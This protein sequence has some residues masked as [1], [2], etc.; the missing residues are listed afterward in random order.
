MGRDGPTFTFS[1]IPYPILYPSIRP[2]T[3]PRRGEDA[4]QLRSAIKSSCT[5]LL[6]AAARRARMPPRYRAPRAAG[7]CVRTAARRAARAHRRARVRAGGRACG[8]GHT[9]FSSTR[10][11]HSGGSTRR[12]SSL[13][14]VRVAR[15]PTALLSCSQRAHALKRGGASRPA[16]RTRG[17][18]VEPHQCQAGVWAVVASTQIHSLASLA[19]L[20]SSNVL[21]PAWP[22]CELSCVCTQA[23]GRHVQPSLPRHADQPQTPL[24]K[25]CCA[26]PPCVPARYLGQAELAAGLR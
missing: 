16:H 5:Q 11:A 7:H 9:L 14:R 4:P 24:K 26:N 25:G 18:C 12:S 19:P 3:P 23:A 20:E 17:R 10:C 2:V 15:M 1:Y 8:R 22:R 13:S 6:D 21:H